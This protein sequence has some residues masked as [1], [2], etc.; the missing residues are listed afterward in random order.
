VRR[1]V[2]LAGTG[3]IGWAAAR[4]L[5]AAGWEVTVTGR[6]PEHVP[7]GLGASGARYVLADR[8][9]PASLPRVMAH[10]ADLLV[11]CACHTAAHASGLLPFLADASSSVMI[12]TKAV[13]VDARGRHSNSNDPPE[14]GRPVSETQPTLRPN[15]AP[16]QSREGYG[17]NKVAAEETLL[18]S[19]HPVTVLRPSKVH[20]SWS[21]QP[22]EWYFVKRVLDRRPAVLLAH[23]GTGADHPSAA[24][25]I[26]A[27]IET[28]ADRPGRRIL[29]I[30]DPDCPDGATI[31]SVVAAH[32]GHS[33]RAVLLDESAPPALGRHPWDRVPP[34][35]LDTTAARELGY[36]P[37]GT[38]AETVVEE[39]DWLVG[40]R[41]T[42]HPLARVVADPCHPGPPDY[43]PEDDYLGSMSGPGGAG[44]GGQGGP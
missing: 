40:I 11:D 5:T 9:D 36:T 2:I 15:R 39:I 8:D 38:Y 6:N 18:A 41:A 13:Y 22:R 23:R 26:A 7:P 33:W 1:A 21:R 28:V 16:Y 43:A 42:G 14:F 44:K 10:G 3:A 4:R 20:G 35:V 32:L 27:L 12:S 30:A 37:A 34:V 25:N 19:G 31:A 29:N 17:P 24:L